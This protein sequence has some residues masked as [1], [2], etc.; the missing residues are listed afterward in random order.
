MK[1]I[2]VISYNRVSTENQDT[3]R[4]ERDI[5]T[6]CKNNNFKVIRKISEKVS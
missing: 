6:Y 2:N 1:K 5:E 3:L 4:Q